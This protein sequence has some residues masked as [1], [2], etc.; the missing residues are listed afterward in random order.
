M[1]NMIE[2]PRGTLLVEIDELR[3][4]LVAE[5][6]SAQQLMLDNDEMLAKLVAAEALLREA[7]EAEW[8]EEHGCIHVP[9]SWYERAKG[10]CGERSK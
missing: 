2:C 8:C 3:A 10:A 9:K 4:K 6:A 5:S 7:V 1:S